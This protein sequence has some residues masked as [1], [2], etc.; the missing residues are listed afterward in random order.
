MIVGCFQPTVIQKSQSFTQKSRTRSE[1]FKFWRL[2]WNLKWIFPV[3]LLRCSE[4]KKNF[5][6][7]YA[8]EGKKIT[9][10]ID[11][12]DRSDLST[13]RHLWWAILRSYLLGC[14]NRLMRVR[15]SKSPIGRVMANFSRRGGGLAI[16]WLYNCLFS[17]WFVEIVWIVRAKSFKM[18]YL[19]GGFCWWRPDSL[20]SLYALL[21]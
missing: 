11:L 16:I 13:A 10:V 12:N 5:F 9:S 6:A 4:S 20:P 7:D 2:F 8:L 19:H 17:S 21:S 1:S 14:Q 3:Q 15:V 18:S